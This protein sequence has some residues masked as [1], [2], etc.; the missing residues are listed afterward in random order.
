MLRPSAFATV[1]RMLG[2][3]SEPKTWCRSGFCAF[4][5]PARAVN[6]PSRRAPTCRRWSRGSRST[7]S[8]ARVRRETYV[9]EWLPEPLLASGDDDPARKAEMADSLSLVFLSC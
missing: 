7:I 3:V 9:G 4:T 8:V 5:A 6:E 1:Y 2:T